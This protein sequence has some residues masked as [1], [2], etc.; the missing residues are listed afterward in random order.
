MRLSKVATRSAIAALMACVLSLACGGDDSTGPSGSNGGSFYVRFRANGSQV[1]FNAANNVFTTIDKVGNEFHFG[2]SGVSPT[3]GNSVSLAVL[4]VSAI[5]TTTYTGFTVVNN[6]GGFRMAQIMY[7]VGG[8]QYENTDPNQ[9]NRITIT[10]ITATTVKGTFSG[11]VKASG[12]PSLSITNGEFFS[13][14]IN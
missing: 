5:T 10:E 12:R 1:E 7:T 6:S 3:T 4:D 13:Q 2:T 8:V 14:R 11:T 9:D